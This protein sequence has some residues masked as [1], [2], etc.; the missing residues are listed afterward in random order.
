MNILTKSQIFSASILVI[1]SLTSC[2]EDITGVDATPEN[3]VTHCE[4]AFQSNFSLTLPCDWEVTDIHPEQS[5]VGVIS[6]GMEEIYFT[7]GGFA[8]DEI[9]EDPT[10]TSYF[11]VL[12][13]WVVF[14]EKVVQGKTVIYAYFESDGVEGLTQKLTFWFV[15]SE[16]E[17]IFK[18]RILSLLLLK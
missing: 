15:K 3:V 11:A 10:T 9:V 17:A 14:Q 6:N 13:G 2:S 5:S 1:L 16:N 7:L 12:D 8:F 4:Q 18:D